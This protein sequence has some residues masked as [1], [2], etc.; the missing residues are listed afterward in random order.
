MKLYGRTISRGKAEGDVIIEPGSVSFLGGV[1]PEEGVIVDNANQVSG[2]SIAG[3]VFAFST[4]KGST[5]GSYVIYRMKKSG[6]APAAIIN[7]RAET[8]VASGAIISGIPMI[9]G[10]DISLLR[11]CDRV[12]VNAD[13]GYVE[14]PGVVIKDAVTVIIK[15]KNRFLILKRSQSVGSC[16]GRWAGVSGHVEGHED[17]EERAM[18]EVEEETKMNARIVGKGDEILARDRSV[19]WRIHPFLAEVDE[20]EE[21]EIDWEHSKYRWIKADEVYDY[22][23]VP[24]LDKVFEN[25]GIL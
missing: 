14:I 3:K 2:Q 9:D 15:R 5:V 24:K 16:K 25:L 10:I 1:D 20:N 7:E 8:I 23:T 6:T 17:M 13:E 21:P 4:G 11:N 18:K 12:V 19:I 22:N